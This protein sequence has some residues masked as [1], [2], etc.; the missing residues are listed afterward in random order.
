MRQALRAMMEQVIVRQ[1]MRKN[2]RQKKGSC[3]R[4]GGELAEMGEGKP[5]HHF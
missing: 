1:P 4:T 2:S 5:A 3:Q